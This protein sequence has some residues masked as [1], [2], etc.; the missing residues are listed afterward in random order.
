MNMIFATRPWSLRYFTISE[1]GK[2]QY[3]DKD[4][5][6][7]GEFLVVG[8]DVKQLVPSEANGNENAFLIHTVEDENIIVAAESESEVTEWLDIIREVAKGKFHLD[9]RLSVLTDALDYDPDSGIKLSLLLDT[10][11]LTEAL[12]RENIPKGDFS[13]IFE[14]Q[15]LDELISKIITCKSRN[16]KF[17][18]SFREKC[19]SL[20][21]R[22]QPNIE[23]PIHTTRTSFSQE[24]DFLIEFRNVPIR[25]D[26][27]CSDILS[28]VLGP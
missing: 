8:A 3:Y 1:D 28:V 22:I 11:L 2:M 27:Y 14:G 20:K 15:Y 26:K 7:K 5:T 18:S 17:A 9:K 19:T 10:K 16:S 6:H 23:L 4:G 25:G 12:S 13:K 21:I 24:G